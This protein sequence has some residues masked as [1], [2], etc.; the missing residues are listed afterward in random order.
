MGLPSQPFRVLPS[1]RVDSAKMEEIRNW[2]D[3]MIVDIFIIS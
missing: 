2:E 1:K 3:R